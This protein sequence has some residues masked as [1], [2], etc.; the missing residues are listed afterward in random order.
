MKLKFVV[1]SCCILLLGGAVG[2]VHSR[3]RGLRATATQTS[4]GT[5]S[6]SASAVAVSRN[7]QEFATTQ[8][9]AT[10]PGSTTF[11]F[12]IAEGQIDECKEGPAN[13]V[14]CLTL[15]PQGRVSFC[16]DIPPDDRFTC[17]QQK[18][19]DKCDSDFIIRD[20]CCLKTCQRCG[21]NCTDQT[22]PSGTACSTGICFTEEVISGPYCLKTCTRCSTAQPE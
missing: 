20:A 1:V 13:Q 8:G 15:A 4:Q 5:E 10:G 19:F 22:P 7:G 11:G 6:A 18:E 14:S 9:S 17:E 12:S 2:P 21:E 3:S 16:S